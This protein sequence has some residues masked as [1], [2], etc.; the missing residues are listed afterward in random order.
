MRE[1]TLRGDLRRQ[2][3]ETKEEMRKKVGARSGVA[4]CCHVLGAAG[5]D[6]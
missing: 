4:V 2:L 5:G 3:D 6:V 1:R